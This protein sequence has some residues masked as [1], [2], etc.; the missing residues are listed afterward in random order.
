MYC[1]PQNHYRNYTERI[2]T[3]KNAITKFKGNTKKCLNYHKEGRKEEAR[4]KGTNRKSEQNGTLK[5]QQ[6][7]FHYVQA[8]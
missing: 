4:T 2:H 3:V 1:N 6:D 5:I 8:A 7:Q